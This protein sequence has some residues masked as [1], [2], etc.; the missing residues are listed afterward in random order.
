[1]IIDALKEYWEIKNLLVWVVF[2]SK[3]F[4]QFQMGS[5]SWPQPN[6]YC[7]GPQCRLWLQQDPL[8]TYK[9]DSKSIWTTAHYKKIIEDSLDILHYFLM[10][11]TYLTI[12]LWASNNLLVVANT[13]ATVNS[14]VAAVRTLG[15]LPTNIFLFF[16]SLM[17]K[18]SKPTDIVATTFSCGPV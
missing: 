14:A 6:Q 4:F 7:Q 2:H 15:V 5:I 9:Q 18:W 3:G 1:M 10:L 12:S 13:I 16:N 11:R 8:H 17:S